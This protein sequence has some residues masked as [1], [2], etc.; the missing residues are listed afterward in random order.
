MLTI[1]LTKGFPE[2][3][4]IVEQI[5]L[6]V[7]R[8]ELRPGERLE[9][10]RGLADRLGVN[11]S[12]VARA[13]RELEQAGVIETHGRR[14]TLVAQESNV[15]GLRQYRETRLRGLAERAVVE[16]LAQGFTPDEIEAALGLQLAAWREQ[17]GPHPA[18]PAARAPDR[19]SR[20]AGSHDLAL[21]ALWAQARQAHPAAAFTAS[22]VGSLNG[23]LALLHGEAGL[24]G[25]HI[26]DEETG[27][28]NLPI[29]RRLF[30]GGQ[31]CAVTLAEREQ[32]LILAAGNPKGIHSLAD[33]LDRLA[34]GALRFINRQ[35]GSGTRTLLEHRLRLLGLSPAFLGRHDQVAATHMAV[36]SAVAQGHADAGLGLRAAA[37]ALGLDFLPI[38][39]ERYDLICYMAD[40][41]QPSLAPL[42]D[43]L[44]SGAFRGVIAQLGGY[45]AEHTGEVRLAG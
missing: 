9:P 37:Q 30:P 40:R 3:A 19:L 32:G 11:P 45:H 41:N 4:Q 20:F 36:A 18:P 35:P 5:R 44:A 43:L 38:A 15:E 42:F 13:Y 22:Y 8:G 39:T 16:A 12:T 17:R 10:V 2:Y 1:H 26:L 23:L 31:V 21:E 29:L 25:A 24:A 14:G 6:A 27:E 28:Y 33:G 34:H 7:A